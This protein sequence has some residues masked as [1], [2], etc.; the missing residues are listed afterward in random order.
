MSGSRRLGSR[1][2]VAAAVIALVLGAGVLLRVPRR[3]TRRPPRLTAELSL[4]SRFADSLESALS[5][6][7][8]RNLSSSDVVAVLYLQRLRL[9]VGSPFR[10]IDYALRDPLLRPEHRPL[11]ADAILARTSVGD[12][13]RTPGEA[14]QLLSPVPDVGR[15]YA[16]RRF[17]ERVIEEAPSPRAAELALRLTYAIGATS[18]VVS[19]RASAVALGAIAQARDRA[20]AMRDVAA[21]LA[22]AR[23][24]HVDPVDLVPAW[25]ATRRF[26]VELPLIDP[27]SADDERAALAYIPHFTLQLDSLGAIAPKAT[28]NKS[29]D[30]ATASAAIEVVARRNAPPQAPITVTLGG[31][32]SFVVGSAHTEA[33]RQ[34]RAVFVT[35]STNEESMVAELARLEAAYGPAP[36]ASLAVLTAAV[37]LRA[38]GQEV[39]WLPGDG[40]PSPLELQSR[41]GLAELTFDKR[42]PEAWRPYFTRMLDGVV[43]DVRSVFP[44]LD[45]AGLHVHFGESPMRERALALHDPGTRT[46][47]FP[48]ATSAGAMAHEL[49]HDLDWQAARRRYGV[50]GGYR[51]DRSVRQYQDGLTASVRRLASA[52]PRR[53]SASSGAGERPTEAFARGVDWFVATA[54]AHQGRL[55]GY[56]SAVQDEMLT[57]YAS[58]T[59]PRPGAGDADATL[60]ALRE[61]APV[62]PAVVAWY[63]QT[64]GHGRRLGVSDAIRRVLLA[65]QPALTVRGAPFLG[66]DAF[67]TSA[68]MFRASPEAGAGWR[69]LLGAPSLEGLDVGAMKAAM[70]FAADERARGMVRR[71]GD[72]ALTLPEASWRFRALGGAPWDGEM[73]ESAVRE[74]RDAMLWRAARIDDG[75]AGLDLAEHAERRATWDRCAAG[76]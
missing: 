53:D 1:T 41:L 7:S 39:A 57:G 71:W 73:Y 66:F 40:G 25:R 19:H 24:Q 10:L 12:A 61:I 34:A 20:L 47:Y 44:A 58:A 63:E 48:L 31:Y 45:L 36:E 70:E 4:G 23:Q 5:F 16:H 28:S 14:L 21:L 22:A 15:G 8:A 54:L 26:T 56:V 35:S 37:A 46:I 50:R 60:D 55:N 33:E 62:D 32:T 17:I 11:L 76:R 27:P 2:V 18:G 29:L 3:G 67:Q 74:L 9:G 52:R 69:C 13:Y 38:Y 49:A 75:R 65:P 51:T 6:T 59:A 64:Y 30:A 68:R 43:R 42:V 72:Y